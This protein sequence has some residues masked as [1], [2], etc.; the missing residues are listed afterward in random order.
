[1]GV[2]VCSANNNL[3]RSSEAQLELEV[4]FGPKVW[5]SPFDFIKE[6]GD[7][8]SNDCFFKA[9]PSPASDSIYWTKKGDPGFRHMGRFLKITNLTLDHQGLYTCNVNNYLN[10][11]GK[12]DLVQRTGRASFELK[13]LHLPGQATIQ[14]QEPVVILGKSVTLTCGTKPQGFPVPKFK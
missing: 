2:Y 11:S 10:L 4:Q 13:I 1:M 7:E 3:G 5:L 14:P 6:E 9:N 12:P 8:L